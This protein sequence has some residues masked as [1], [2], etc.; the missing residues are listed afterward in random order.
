MSHSPK[1]LN[2]PTE[3][4]DSIG[5]M[6]PANFGIDLLGQVLDTAALRHR[7]IAQNVANVNT[8]GYKRLEVAFEGELRKALGSG[9][10]PSSAAPKVVATDSP[11]RVDGNTVDIDREMNDVVKNGL[12]YQ[13]VSQILAS[14]LASMKSAISG[15]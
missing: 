3:S 7:V 11:E 1:L 4:V 14:R 6:T 13:A 10:A 8:P 5:T 12:L 2:F 9:T 15:R